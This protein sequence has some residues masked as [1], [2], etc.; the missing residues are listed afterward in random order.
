MLYYNNENE[1]VSCMR[2]ISPVFI[3]LCGVFGAVAGQFIWGGGSMTILG[4][5]V[6]LLVGVAFR[7]YAAHK[8]K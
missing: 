1:G 7:I 8:P 5:G 4:L 2:K 6:G 3:P